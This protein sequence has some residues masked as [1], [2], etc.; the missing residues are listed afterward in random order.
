VLRR[1]VESTL[2]LTIALADIPAAL[3]VTAGERTLLD[4]AKVEDVL[5]VISY[6]IG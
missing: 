5:L 4:P 2:S 6:S 3:G 1:P